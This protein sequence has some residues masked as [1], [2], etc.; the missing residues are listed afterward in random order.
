M[1]LSRTHLTAAV[2]LTLAALLVA[3]SLLPADAQTPPPDEDGTPAPTAETPPPP[4]GGESDAPVAGAANCVTPFAE[5]D[6]IDVPPPPP[7][8]RISGLERCI[9]AGDSDS[10]TVTA[11]NLVRLR[12]YRVEVRVSRSPSRS[13]GFNSSCSSTTH[14]RG[15]IGTTS[16]SLSFRLY[17]CPRRHRRHCIRYAH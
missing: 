11:S 15:I 2:L 3:F 4:A 9:D 12:S 8:V 14:S 1:T 5:A 13:M 7:R 10:F 16:R 6:S 17:G